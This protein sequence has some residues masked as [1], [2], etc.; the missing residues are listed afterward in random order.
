MGE[1]RQETG[2][3]RR[4]TGD[5]RRETAA[6]CS[7][8]PDIFE[9]SVFLTCPTYLNRFGRSDSTDDWGGGET[10][11]TEAT[12]EPAAANLASREVT[13]NRRQKGCKHIPISE[14]ETSGLQSPVFRARYC[15]STAA[16]Y[17]R[18]LA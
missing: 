9:A 8:R 10:E 6:C 4:E 14:L 3:R 11:R 16:M 15:A 5:G 1:G 7:N 2:D 17:S 13:S 12:V 18:L